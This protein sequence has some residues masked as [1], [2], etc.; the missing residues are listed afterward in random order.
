M[1]GIKKSTDKTFRVALIWSIM[2]VVGIPLIVIGAVKHTGFWW[3]VM[4]F[5]IVCVATGL[6]AVPLFWVRYAQKRRLWRVALAVSSSESQTIDVLS[7]TLGRSQEE[8]RTDVRTLL[9]NG[10]LPGYAFVDQEDR[11]RRT[12]TLDLHH[13][14]CDYCGATFEFQGTNAKC[15]YCGRFFIGEPI[16]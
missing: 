9:R 15:P 1:D 6:F 8:T 4:V 16:D 11:V 2:F 12:T 3:L 13:A 10:W 5:G 14:R 7:D